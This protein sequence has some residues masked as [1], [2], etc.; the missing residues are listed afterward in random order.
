MLFLEVN[1]RG[2]VIVSNGHIASVLLRQRADLCYHEMTL[3]RVWEVYP[4]DFGCRLWL[5]LRLRRLLQLEEALLGQ[6]FVTCLQSDLS[7][8]LGLIFAETPCALET[9]SIHG[10]DYALI[11]WHLLLAQSVITRQLDVSDRD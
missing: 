6:P 9:T 10:I 8:V 1:L 5:D 7:S 2:R 3:L 4:W 11:L